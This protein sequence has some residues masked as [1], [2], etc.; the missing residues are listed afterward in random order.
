[1]STAD[2]PPHD[3]LLTRRLEEDEQRYRSL[4]EQ[5]VDA[6][7]SFDLAGRFT[8]ANAAC[9]LVSGYSP[10][11]LRGTPFL[12][13]VVPE[14]REK[15]QGVFLGAA[16]GTPQHDEIAILHK[17]GR[18]VEVNIAK[19]PIV[20]DGAV[21]GIYGIAKDVTDRNRAEAALRQSESW[22]RAV[23]EAGPV[24]MTI[25]RWA[26]GAIFYANR[27]VRDLF[28]VPPGEDIV[29]Q[30]TQQFFVSPDD[31]ARLVGALAEC[32][33]V[34]NWESQARR[35]DGTTFWASG[36]FQRMVYR[37]EDAVYSVYRD[38][39]AS[40][41]LLD[42]ARAEAERDPLTGLLNH[43]AFQLR[44]EQEADRARSGGRTLAVAVFDWTISSSSTTPT[45]TPWAMKCCARSPAPCG[46]PAGR[47]TAWPVSAATSSPC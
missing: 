12:P 34:Q 21:V 1:M 20:V 24:A 4:F 8:E 26:D 27:H 31:R 7:F 9:L 37:G 30:S 2:D 25:T 42:E 36:A 17:S 39:S 35:A 23:A 44:L 6:V 16:G 40:R 41:L 38:V 28:R 5:N 14:D 18:R 33:H 32:G 43:R 46:P 29:G 10:E 45:P 13:L 11:E 47:A 15:A 3:P 19:V 22:L